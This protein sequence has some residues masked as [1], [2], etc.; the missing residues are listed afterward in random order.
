MVR[1]SAGVVTGTDRAF[2]LMLLLGCVFF[3]G[4]VSG[5]AKADRH[6]YHISDNGGG[7]CGDVGAWD[8]SSR[9]CTLTRDTDGLFIIESDDVTLDGAGHAMI[10]TNDG[11]RHDDGSGHAVLVVGRRG[12]TV[13]NL[14]VS[15][16]DYAVNLEFS[17][18]CIVSGI[19]AF[20]NA[21]AGVSLTESSGNAVSGNVIT[22]GGF[23]TGICIGFNSN[24]NEIAGNTISGAERAIFIHTLCDA[25]RV[26]DND[27]LGNSWAVTL[28]DQDSANIVDGNRIRQNALGVYL[29]GNSHDNIFSDND[30]IDNGQGVLLEGAANNL[31]FGNSFVG[32]QV[33]AESTGGGSNSFNLPA[34]PGGN[35]W[36]DFDEEAEGC[37]DNGIGF[38]ETAYGFEGG[39][40]ALPRTAPARQLYSRP[41]L[42]VTPAAAFESMMHSKTQQMEYRSVQA[43]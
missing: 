19:R 29:L 7:D 25:N 28:F 24:D 17:S 30:I 8:E 9:T 1:Q 34:A 13:K 41:S 11:S 42:A 36:D 4:F 33:Q 27:L 5:E 10:G 18:G 22:N 6:I 26:S 40:D 39:S 15:R 43:I 3:L 35:Y 31:F 23:D 21:Y 37:I 20:E 14:M 2:R 16:Y 38:C 12:V 32:N